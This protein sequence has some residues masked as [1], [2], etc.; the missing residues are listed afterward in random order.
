MGSESI[1]ETGQ[2]ANDYH[3]AVIDSDPISRHSPPAYG[4]ST[5]LKGVSIPSNLGAGNI[6]F[7]FGRTPVRLVT[8]LA[9]IG[10][11]GRPPH[12]LPIPVYRH[13]DARPVLTTAGR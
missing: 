12:P 1:Y 3:E 5:S 13:S 4:G 7:R 6:K 11:S 8:L 10:R 2:M 9:V